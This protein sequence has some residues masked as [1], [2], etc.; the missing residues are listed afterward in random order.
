MPVSVLQTVM[1]RSY[2]DE[3]LTL[4]QAQMLAV[5]VVGDY[6]GQAATY[7]TRITCI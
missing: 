3:A 7:L 2:Q 5:G 4:T 1:V 6:E